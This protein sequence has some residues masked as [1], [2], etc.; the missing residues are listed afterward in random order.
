MAIA[1]TYLRLSRFTLI[2]GYAYLVED[3]MQLAYYSGDL[4]LEKTRVHCNTG[5][6]W[7]NQCR[8]CMW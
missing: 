8:C 2:S 5:Y 4:V 7:R 1:T 3:G 6:R